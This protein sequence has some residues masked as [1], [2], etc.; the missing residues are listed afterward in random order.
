MST[1]TWQLYIEAKLRY[2][3]FSKGR[4]TFRSG[5]A[6]WSNSRMWGYQAKRGFSQVSAIPDP[7][8]G[9]KPFSRA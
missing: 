3:S 8:L 7:G 1:S 4:E 2:N 6:G 5:D 9:W